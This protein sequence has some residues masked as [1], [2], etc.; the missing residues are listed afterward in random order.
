MLRLEP[1]L[2]LLVG[3]NNAGKSRVLRALAVALGAP[4]EVDDFTVGTTHA[5]SVDV[6]IAPLPTASP[7]GEETFSES[8]TDRLGKAQVISEGPLIERFAWR[9]RIVRS[10]EG[11]GARSE[12]C[13]L[14][15]DERTERW[16]LPSRPS[17]LSRE[18]RSVLSVELVDTR[19]DLFEELSKRGSAV[20]RILSDLEVDIRSRRQLEAQLAALS[21]RIVAQ[22]AALQAVRDSLQILGRH[23][24]SLGEPALNPLPTRLEELARS[25]D[26]DLDTGR[27]ALP[28]R[29]HG[30][31]AR[32]LASLQIQGLN[33]ERRLG[34][35]GPSTRP[36]PVTLVEEPEAHLHP[37]AEFELAGL[38]ERL[39]GQVIASTHSSHVVTS[40][41][42]RCIR[43]S[44]PG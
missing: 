27:G 8:V 12:T 34:R 17:A 5:P 30:A 11:L 9:T 44:P 15:F 43:L 37:Q 2:T 39:P 6:V 10:G 26:I 33:Y 38:L 22:S 41:E 16:A 25:I 20:R 13:Q 4:A 24:A 28:L 1:S 19:R 35:D 21:S 3:R 7:S 23:M 36:H 14:E 31:G 32:S 42:P 40:V 18:Q 29:L